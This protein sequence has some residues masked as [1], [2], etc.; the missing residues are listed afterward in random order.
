MSL[1][2]DCEKKASTFGLFVACP[3]PRMHGGDGGWVAAVILTFLL[4]K[5]DGYDV[6]IEAVKDHIWSLFLDRYLN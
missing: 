1:K 2:G 6:K 3:W 4:T 5:V